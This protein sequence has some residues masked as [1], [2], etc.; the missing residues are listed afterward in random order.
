MA[1]PST[2]ISRVEMSVGFEEFSLEASRRGFI[3]PLVLK[4]RIVSKQAASIGQVPLAAHLQPRDTARA[5]RSGYARSTF[6]FGTL[7]YSCQEHGAEETIDD[8]ELSIY[9]DLIDQETIH[10]QRAIDA[11]LR[12]Y[13]K[14]VADAVFDAAT[15]TGDYTTGISDE[16]DDPANATPVD[17]VKSAMRTVWERT[18]LWPNCLIMTRHHLDA[19]QQCDQITERMIYRGGEGPAVVTRQA[20]AQI[21]GIDQVLVADAA[22]NSATEGQAVEISSIW[23]DEYVMVARVATT[24]DMG[25]ACLGRTFLFADD[26]AGVNGNE[27]AVILEE[28]RQED[29]RGSVLRARTYWDEKITMKAAGQLL[30]NAIS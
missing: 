21:F 13:E 6:Q 5:P 7:D 2:S 26:G 27:L 18:G 29:V 3:G 17:D 15:W 22:Y 12:D 10:A 11:V 28:Y 23:S 14:A 19:L 4:P 16:W 25:E 30:T 9:R 20:L 1:S 8:S 24:D